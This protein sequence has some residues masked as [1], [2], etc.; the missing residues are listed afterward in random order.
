MDEMQPSPGPQ[1]VAATALA[2][3]AVG[4]AAALLQFTGLGWTPFHTR[5]EPREAVVVQDLVARG[6]WILPR[7]NATQLPRKPPLFY[8]LAGAAAQV[9]GA[10]DE[11]SVRLPSALLSA[12]AA[13]LLTLA[14]SLSLTPR[15]GALA[16]LMLLTS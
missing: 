1:R 9:R 10:V 14:V 12:A 15:A 16:G 8:W 7:R 13:L 4:A 3:I 5:G 11:A 6:D 2:L